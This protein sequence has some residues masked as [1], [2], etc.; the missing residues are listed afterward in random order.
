MVTL[1]TPYYLIDEKKLQENLLKIERLRRLSGAKVVLATKCFSTWSVFKLMSKY[2]DGTTGSSLYEARLGFEKFGGETHVYSVGYT[3]EEI[4]YLRTFCDKIIFNS[5]S[6]LKAFAPLLG[7]KNETGLRINPGISSSN[8]PLSDPCTKYSRLGVSDQKEILDNLGPVDG[9]LF[10]FNCDNGSY[11]NLE[12]SLIKICGAYYRVLDKVKWVSFGGGVLFT[13]EGYPLEA[14]SSL[15]KDIKNSYAVQVY[16][17]PGEA[18]VS[19]C[20]E[21]VTTVVDIVQNGKKIAVVDASVEAHMLDVMTYK[22]PL[23]KEEG[24]YEYIIAGRSCLAGDVF[25]TQKLSRPLRVGDEIRFENAAGY[26]MV[27]KNWFNGLKMP[28]IVIKRLN[29]KLDLV[30]ESNYNNFKNSLS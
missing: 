1:K 29:G 5:T 20:A 6:Q 25:G 9:A 18:A 4:L 15:L 22:T 11:D 10:H 24:P 12:K 27:K 3:R 23:T 21:L 26:T 16:L 19:N 17:E 8:Y 13:K 14:L 30:Q 2:M 7:K 28:S